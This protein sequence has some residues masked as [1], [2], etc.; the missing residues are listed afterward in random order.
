MASVEAVIEKCVSEIWAQYDKD[1]NGHLDKKESRAF[2][3]QTLRDMGDNSSFTEE[4][5]ETTFKEF[6][7]NG[8]GTIDRKEMASFIKKVAGL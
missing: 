4:D 2:I 1:N 3:E 8:D 5:F 6:D 7:K